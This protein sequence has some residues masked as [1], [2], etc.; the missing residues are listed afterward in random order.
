MATTPVPLRENDPILAR[1]QDELWAVITSDRYASLS[2]AAT[3][4]VLEFVKI[5]VINGSET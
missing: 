2:T 4:G 5:N 1:L 3:V